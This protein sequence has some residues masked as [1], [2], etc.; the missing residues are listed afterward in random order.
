VQ[1]HQRVWVGDPGLFEVFDV[2]FMAGDPTTALRQPYSMVISA[3]VARRFFGDEDPIGRIVRWDTSHEHHITGVVEAPTN[4]HLPLDVTVSMGVVD[5]EPAWARVQRTDS[6]ERVAYSPNFTYLL[7]DDPASAAGLP[8]RIEGLLHGGAGSEYAQALAQSGEVLRVQA[9]R[10][11]HLHSRFADEL[12]EPGDAQRVTIM[13]AVA[14]LLLLIACA[15]YVNLSTARAIVRAHEVGVRKASGASRGHLVRQF[16]GESVL[17]MAAAALVGT[18]IVYVTL[19]A[20]GAFLGF[21]LSLSPA[22]NPQVLL[23]VTFVVGTACLSGLYPAFVLSRLQPTAA[24]TDATQQRRGGFLRRRITEVQLGVS[25]ALIA[26]TLT[27]EGQFDY[28]RQRNLGFET[29]NVIYFRTGYPGVKKQTRAIRQ[30][31]ARLPGVLASSSFSQIPFSPFWA[32]REMR[33]GDGDEGVHVSRLAVDAG[34]A[35]VFQHRL[36]AGRDLAQGSDSEALLNETAVWAFGY[37]DAEQVVGLPISIAAGGQTVVG[38]VEDYH[39]QSLRTAISPVV[40]F[41]PNWDAQSFTAL[42]LRADDLPGT[43]A[44]LGDTWRQFAPE[45]PFAYHFMDAD[46]EALYRSEERLAQ[47]LSLF[48]LLALAV[49]GMGVFALG[50]HEVA[51]RRREISIRKVLGASAARI[52]SLLTGQLTGSLAVASVVAWIAVDHVMGPWLDQ[53]AY[54][55]DP[56]AWVYAMSALAMLLTAWLT[57]GGQALRAA[58]RNPVVGLRQE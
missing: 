44:A 2:P 32:S 41:N 36:V 16:F 31:M 24:L 57:V 43:L 42:R 51:Q 47:V 54:R 18:V 53:F 9:S 28:M 15:N 23:L 49:A 27:V 5:V 14:I 52:V 38:V 19:P 37:D 7:L 30:A 21:E 25:V 8:G 4:T 56:G 40:L 33:L 1:F 39:F 58:W 20:F 12:T 13:A 3:A 46:F 45:Y 35:A 48:S 10:D 34:Y 11:I 26:V 50:L 29:Q 22:R 17:T 55:A 6:W